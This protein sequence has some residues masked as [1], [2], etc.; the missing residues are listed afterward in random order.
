[1]TRISSAGAHTPGSGAYLTNGVLYLGDAG[2]INTKQQVIGPSKAFSNDSS[3]GVVSLEHLA[4]ELQP[5][6]D[7]VKVLATARSGR[8]RD[9]R[10]ADGGAEVDAW[11]QLAASKCS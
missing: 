2:M 7:E 3:Q 5:R 9:L 1:M 4:Q 11:E 8:W 6:A 10:R